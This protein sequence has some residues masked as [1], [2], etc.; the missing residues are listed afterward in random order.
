MRWQYVWRHFPCN[1]STNH[2]SRPESARGRVMQHFLF[3]YGYILQKIN[4]I[5]STRWRFQKMILTNVCKWPVY[6]TGLILDLYRHFVWMLVSGQDILACLPTGYGKSCVYQC[7]PGLCLLLAK[8]AYREWED[9]AIILVSSH[10]L[11]L[12]LMASHI[13]FVVVQSGCFQ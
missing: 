9:V 13:M 6:Y 10:L 1:L 3:W 8:V 4:S 11:N 12:R 2:R 7:W 5:T